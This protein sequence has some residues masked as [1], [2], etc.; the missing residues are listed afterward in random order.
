MGGANRGKSNASLVIM[1][2][3]DLALVT[4]HDTLVQ[5]SVWGCSNIPS[6]VGASQLDL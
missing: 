1:L 3:L 2:V 4:V 6:A 5:N